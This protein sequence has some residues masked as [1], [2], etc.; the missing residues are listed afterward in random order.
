MTGKRR[1]CQ[2]NMNFSKH[3]TDIKTFSYPPT[4][5]WTHQ[6]NVSEKDK[7][8]LG[9]RKPAPVITQQFQCLSSTGSFK[10]LSLLWEQRHAGQK[11]SFH[12]AIQL[13][14]C[15]GAFWQLPCISSLISM[16]FYKQ[17]KTQENKW[18]VVLEEI[19]LHIKS[20]SSASKTE[21]CTLSVVTKS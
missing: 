13:M 5:T 12:L 6:N 16:V 15:L 18:P 7:K 11:V 2:T 8:M 10:F 3:T 19:A 4:S 9:D 20:F 21:M 14:N 17:L 1:F